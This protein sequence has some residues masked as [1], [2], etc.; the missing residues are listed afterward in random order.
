MQSYGAIFLLGKSYIEQ[1]WLGPSTTAVLSH[2]LSRRVC[3]SWNAVLKP[4]YTAGR[5]SY[6]NGVNIAAELQVLS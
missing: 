6:L 3:L 5:G 1:R 2:W 4:E